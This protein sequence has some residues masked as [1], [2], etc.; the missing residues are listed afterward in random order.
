VVEGQELV[1]PDD[2]GGRHLLIFGDL[3]W[4]DYS[5]EAEIK[6]IGAGEDVALIFRARGP[7]KRLAACLLPSMKGVREKGS[8]AVI[9]RNEHLLDTLSVVPG[10]TTEGRWYRLRVEAHGNRFTMFVDD[11]LIASVDSDDFPRGCVGLV[12]VTASA[13]F[14]NL[15]VTDP[16]GK[17]LLEGVTGVLPKMR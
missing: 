2:S 1:Q 3:N 11:K 10:E 16:D 17:V 5:F 4:T 13:R 12:A 7:L 15:K 8:R 14:R 9:A 6:I